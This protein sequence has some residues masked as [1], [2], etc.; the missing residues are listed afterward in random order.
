M[1]DHSNFSTNRTN[2]SGDYYNPYTNPYT[3]QAR[4]HDQY[5]IQLQIIETYIYDCVVISKQNL[6]DLLITAKETLGHPIDPNIYNIVVDHMIR[7]SQDYATDFIKALKA[8]DDIG[9]YDYTPY[10]PVPHRLFF[11]RYEVH[12]TARIGDPYRPTSDRDTDSDSDTLDV[13]GDAHWDH[14]WFISCLTLLAFISIRILAWWATN[15][16]SSTGTDTPVK[17]TSHTDHQRATNP[18]AEADPTLHN[19]YESSIHSDIV[20]QTLYAVFPLVML[21]YT[22]RYYFY[23]G[24]RRTRRKRHRSR[25]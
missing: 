23:F 24:F 25:I 2:S 20:V 4:T 14:I 9:L 6:S 22:F 16:V 21:L 7:V 1:E 18:E 5:E 15:S 3:G 19:S 17:I 11:E 8:A 12:V 13:G 10:I